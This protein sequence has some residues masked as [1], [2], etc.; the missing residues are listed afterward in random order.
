MSL[1]TKLANN[2]LIC[3]RIVSFFFC[4]VYLFFYFYIFLCNLYMF[5]FFHSR[6][7]IF[8]KAKK[9]SKMFHQNIFNASSVSSYFLYIPLITSPIHNVYP[10]SFSLYLTCIRVGLRNFLK[11]L[12]YLPRFFYIIFKKQCI[13][14]LCP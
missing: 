12:H 4:I 14:I 1:L 6:I 9:T 13:R 3:I 2:F 8:Y 10:F 7:S 11:L 5:L